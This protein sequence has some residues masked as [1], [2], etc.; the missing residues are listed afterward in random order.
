M[1]RAQLLQVINY[2]LAHLR[3]SVEQ[4]SHLN[5]HDINV[6]AENFFRDLL[7]LAFGHHL[8]NINIIEPNATAVDLGC[9]DSRIAIQVTSTSDISKIRHTHARFTA[10]GLQAKYDHL[11]VLIVG[12]KKAYKETA[13]EAD[14]FS[15]SL[16]DD[17]WDFDDLYR[18]IGD[19]DLSKLQ[20]C[21]DFLRDELAIAEPKQS[22]E[23]LTLVRLVEVLSSEDDGPPTGD[24]R[25]DP[26]PE[27]KIRDR[28]ADHSAFLEE[29]YVELHVI[30]GRILAEV[31]KHSDLSHGRLRKLRM[32]LMNW[33]DRI[34]TGCGG[35]PKAAL[36]LLTQNVLGM[37][38]TS[39]GGF[40]DG[41]VRYYLIHQL[42]M[43][44][45]FPNKRAL[46]V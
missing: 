29:Q 38:G 25:E 19:L 28:F 44:N 14:G 20:R 17:V 7:N 36:D 1:N 4:S 5:L 33:S 46:S 23:V 40:D 42:I 31:N 39:Q 3:V 24:N 22:N 21:Y 12:Q 2:R 37:M 6:H 35:N 13:L 30:Y 27:G 18:K 11:V 9:D 16:S 10:K 32:F 15:M 45:V 41:A 26:D 43:C 34:L 8:K